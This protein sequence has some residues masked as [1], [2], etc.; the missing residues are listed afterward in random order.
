MERSIKRNRLLAVA[1]VLVFG[2][3][4][5]LTVIADDDKGSD[6]SSF[7]FEPNSLVLSRSVYTG[8]A[9]TVTPGQTLPPGCVAGAVQVPL[10]AGGT[11]KVTV[12]CA[13]ATDNGEYPNLLDSHN[14]WNNDTADGSFGVTSPIFLDNINTQG[15]LIGTL[16]VP[17]DVL[18]TS[19][20]SKSE[21]AVN[22][23][24]DGKS[25]TFVGYHGGPGFL[26][27]TNQLDVSNSNTPGVVDPTNPVVSNYYR[28]VAE[29]DASGK[30]TLTDGNAYSGNNGRAA[31][32]AGSYYYMA[33]NDNNGGLST[34]Q[35]TKTQVG[36]NLVAS[37]GAELLIPGQAPP[38]PPNINM[39]GDF[40]ITQAGYTKADKPGKDNNFRGLTVFNNTLFVTKGSGGNGINTVYQVGN[41][42]VVPTPTDHANI[43]VTIL[44]GF[45][46][47][48]ASGV[49]QDGTAGHPVMFPFGIWFANAN[50]LY[51]CDEGDGV[52]V[53][54]RTINGQTNIA[55]DASLATAG[56]QKWTLQDGTWHLVYTL[57]EG[58]D[59]GVP[60]SIAN[61]PAALN[62]A[63]GGCRN[64]TGHANGDGSVGLFAITSTLSQNGDQGA[65]PNKLVTVKDLLN[66]SSLPAGS[67]S[68]DNH[69]WGHF[70][71]LRTAQAGEVLRGIAFSP[72]SSNN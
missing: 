11:A 44:P 52:L 46:T 62:P 65:D 2:A 63:T 68:S 42:G 36:L 70:Q 23:A 32:K 31:I 24:A 17:S 56:I 29:V 12:S 18:V 64:L 34:S 37:T 59:I 6:A 43:P 41:T 9:S 53:A 67:G 40:E 38:F 69:G 33:G 71:V 3:T 8:I 60:Y 19:F 25:I 47:T 72:S 7:K 14:V 27:A 4:A 39:L 51:V 22:L 61:Y 55:D 30:I 15:K 13:A 58:L 57:Q 1:A 10:I 5:T 26:T 21:L 16:P 45:P 54:P 50:T 66:S 48:L 20:S 49:A 35:L 28:S